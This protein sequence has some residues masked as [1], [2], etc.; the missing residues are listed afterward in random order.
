MFNPTDINKLSV[1]AMQLEA[2]KGKNVIKDKKSY[3]FKKKLKGNWKSNKS[4]IVNQVEERHACSHY[5][6]KVHEEA[7]CWKMHPEL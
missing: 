7:Q 2:S 6:R 5:K 4:S 3:K 1:Q